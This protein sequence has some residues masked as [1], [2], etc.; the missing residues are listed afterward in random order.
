MKKIHV[1]PDTGAVSLCPAR[2]KCTFSGESG[3]EN[4]YDTRA[5]ANKR[6]EEVHQRLAEE[7]Q[8]ENKRKKQLAQAY[9]LYGKNISPFTISYSPDVNRLVNALRDAGLRPLLAGGAIRDAVV[10]NT[11]GSVIDFKDLDF[12]VYPADRKNTSITSENITNKLVTAARTVGNVDEVGKAFGVLKMTLKDG[13]EIDLSL[14]RKESKTGAGHKGFDITPDIN[15][16]VEEA[17][18]RRDFT[19]N[20]MLYDDEHKVIIDSHNGLEDLRNKRLRHTSEAFA[21]DPLRVL[22]GFQFAS[23]FGFSLDD[24]TKKLSTQLF[25]EYDTISSERIQVEWDKWASKGERPSAGL[26]VLEDTKW[27]KGFTG[28][29]K[30][31]NDRTRSAADTAALLS[32]EHGTDRRVILPAVILSQIDAETPKKRYA[33]RRA[34]VNKTIIGKT[35]QNRAVTLAETA[36]DDYAGIKTADIAT[37]ADA[38]LAALQNKTSLKERAVLSRALASSANDADT[39]KRLARAENVIAEAGVWERPEEDLVSGNDVLEL[40]GKA[41]GKWMSP[42]IFKVKEAQAQE[43]FTTTEE[44]RQWVRDQFA[45][46]YQ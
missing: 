26:K 25:S 2:V 24:R 29:E 37:T 6:S 28:L 42:F 13:T 9:A 32:N 12:E 45:N 43:K 17:S 44:G 4:H 7:E 10:N 8:A 20:S 40:S 1:N 33:D 31:N 30:A 22:R 15:L 27:D 39:Q 41:P 11:D 34:F 36:D 18:A 14:P 19:L 16:S 21:E 23:R 3:N 35:H 5:E 38:K 46:E